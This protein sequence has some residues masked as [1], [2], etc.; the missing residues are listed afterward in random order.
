MIVFPLQAT[1]RQTATSQHGQPVVD[2]RRLRALLCSTGDEYVAFSHL[3]AVFPAAAAMQAVSGRLDR[4]DMIVGLAADGAGDRG[5]GTFS[6][7]PAATPTA[8]AETGVLTPVPGLVRIHGLCALERALSGLD[9]EHDFAATLDGKVFRRRFLLRCLA[10]LRGCTVAADAAL[11]LHCMARAGQVACVALRFGARPPVGAFAL[12]KRALA[13]WGVACPVLAQVAAGMRGAAEHFH[14]RLAG[15]LVRYYLGVLF[16][17]WEARAPDRAEGHALVSRVVKGFREHGDLFRVVLE[18]GWDALSASGRLALNTLECGSFEPGIL[19]RGREE[20][21]RIGGMVLGERR[22]ASGRWPAAGRPLVSIVTAARNLRE[23][24]RIAYFELMLDSVRRQTYPGTLIEHL[25]VDGASTDGTLEYLRGLWEQG[26]ISRLVSE[27]DSGVYNAMNK[28]VS[29]CNGDCFLFLNS[30][31]YLDAGAIAA[32]VQAMEEGGADYAFAD[33]WQIDDRNNK[34]GVVEGEID[35][36]WFK[37]PYCHQTL[38]CRTS[39]LA[40]FR[41]DES[42]RITMMRYALD[43]VLER[44]RH[45]YVPEKL[46][47]YRLGDGIS[48]A[49][50]NRARYE[51]EL[52]RVRGYCATRIGL[53]RSDYDLLDRAWRRV[54]GEAGLSTFR[55]LADEVRARNEDAPLVARFAESACSYAGLRAERGGRT[56]D[57]PRVA[58]FNSHAYGGAGGAVRRLHLAL[59]RDGRVRS[60]LVSRNMS[61]GQGIPGSELLPMPAA[62]WNARQDEVE[63]RPGYTQFTVDESCVER[64]VLEDIVRRHDVISLQWTARMLS[65]DDIAFLTSMG[66]PVVITL[67]DM[68]PITGGCHYFH[69][70]TAWRDS[71]CGNCPQIVRGDAG[72]AART[73]LAKGRGWRRDSLVFVALSE[74]SSSVLRESPLAD[75]CRVETIGNGFD[76]DTFQVLDHVHARQALGVPDHLANRFVIGMLPS[77]DSL[78]KG[79]DVAWGALRRAAAESA[80]FRDECALLVAGAPVE[81]VPCQPGIP[82]HSVGYLDTAAA[83]NLFY[84]ACDLVIVPSREE[85]FSNTVA[86][87]L[88]SGTPVFGATAGAIPEMVLDGVSGALFSHDWEEDRIARALLDCVRARW[89]RL[90]CRGV[91]TGRFSVSTQVDRY[92]AL[93][94]DL[95]VQA[96]AGERRGSG[97]EAVPL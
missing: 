13:D 64:S 39:R 37:V 24:D 56:K 18:Y 93:F 67:R 30:D 10:A 87:S 25:V 4:P 55:D 19:E 1:V 23:Q 76:C 45:A 91:I 20:A 16:A 94:R 9:W 90:A 79:F 15:W 66:K 48:S 77:F 36:A 69:G 97:K 43:L 89:D 60:T 29:Y 46:A 12:G 84:S 17:A 83:L 47:F 96:S 35:S 41:F 28:A 33:A 80:T 78:V 44:Y 95:A 22:L 5:Q 74:I 11:A 32:L 8:V 65:A 54:R 92:V 26:R 81:S 14:R 85:T 63:I 51:A 3:G 40:G 58:L 88:L 7:E 68:E 59:R 75:G 61:K 38:L 2:I 57:V 42:Y 73:F 34:I 70:C 6:C 72:L 71:A 52:D 86:E 50:R 21:G 49:P 27:P 62:G 53:P 82:F 31:D